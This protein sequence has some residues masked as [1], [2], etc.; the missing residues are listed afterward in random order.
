M[1]LDAVYVALEKLLP[2]RRI[3]GLFEVFG[4][5]YRIQFRIIFYHGSRPL[6]VV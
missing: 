4:R 5:R 2:A 6:L 1:L 3:E